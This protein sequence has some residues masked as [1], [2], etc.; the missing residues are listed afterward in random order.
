MRGSD[1]LPITSAAYLLALATLVLI[2]LS[3]GAFSS[4]FATMSSD[5]PFLC[6]N[7]LS[8]GGDDDVMVL[9]FAVFAMPLLIRILCLKRRVATSE[10]VLFW[11]CVFLVS[12]ALMVASMGCASIFYTAFVVPDIMLAMA[13]LAMPVCA[14]LLQRLRAGR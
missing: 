5:G 2:G 11:V 6:S 10:V 4:G 9:A 8:S 13:L 7:L 12:A 1:R 14:W 3:Y